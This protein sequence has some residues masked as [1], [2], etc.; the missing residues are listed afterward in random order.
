MGKE[1]H[2]LTMPVKRVL[3]LVRMMEDMFVPLQ[4]FQ[5]IGVK[6]N[7]LYLKENYGRLLLRNRFFSY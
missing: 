6:T 7:S 3:S 1:I 4:L 5:D 2:G